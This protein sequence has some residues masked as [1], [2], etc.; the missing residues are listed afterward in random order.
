MIYNL[1]PL[2]HPLD[3]NL[4]GCS[5]GAVLLVTMDFSRVR[6]NVHGD[7]PLEE[8]LTDTHNKFYLSTKAIVYLSLYC[9]SVFP[10]LLILSTSLDSSLFLTYACDFVAP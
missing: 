4:I 8:T 5:T 9:F 6:S 1:Q 7:V 10:G 3:Q 2:L